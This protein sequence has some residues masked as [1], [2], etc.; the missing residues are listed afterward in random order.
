[1]HV[2]PSRT[3]D[4]CWSS[5]SFPLPEKGWRWTCLRRSPSLESAHE[6]KMPRRTS[7]ASAGLLM[8]ASSNAWTN[9]TLHGDVGWKMALLTK[10]ETALA[11]GIGF[12]LLDWFVKKCPKRGE[13]RKLLGVKVGSDLHFDESEVVAFRSYL[14]APWPLPPKGQRP[15]IPDKIKQDIKLE[16]HLACA[17]CG[18]MDNGE[19]AHIEAVASTFNNSPDNL[20]FLC[21]NH[22]TKFDLGFKPA[23]NVSVE[24][25]QAAKSVKRSSR[26][27]MMR[28]EADTIKG[29]AGLLDLI[30]N[31]SEKIASIEGTPTAKVYEAEV[32]SLLKQSSS[33]LADAV[34]KAAKGG[35]VAS[36]LEVQFKK[37]AP[38]LAKL[39]EKGASATT[40]PRMKALVDDVIEESVDVLAALDEQECPH[41]GG[42]GTT[43]LVGDYCKF[44]RGSQLVSSERASAYEPTDLDEVPCP[45]CGGRGTTG[46][47]GDYCGFCR[48]SQGV[49]KEKAE[50]YDE[51]DVDE[52]PCPRCNGRGTTGLVGNYCAYCRGSAYV[53]RSK[54]AAYEADD[55]DE[56][57][58]PHCGGRGTVGL[59]G[60]ECPFC[61]ASQS[62]SSTKA[63]A[64]D[65]SKLDEFDCPHCNGRGVT[66]LNGTYCA[67][68]NGSQRISER[69]LNKYDQ[70]EID[71]VECPH[72][73]GQG[74]IGMSGE[75]CKLC[76]G[77]Q[78]VSEEKSTSYLSRKNTR[79]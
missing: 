79:R 35:N 20:I 65:E 66:G 48:G 6:G 9:I 14:R 32:K 78:T 18:H 17:I 2:Q 19:V 34:A 43:G 11:L 15:T 61:R 67:Y 10:I 54:H 59:V 29:F 5:G 63:K 12:E 23:S 50:S 26:A 36:V 25:I 55:I 75:F 39:L 44:C 71:E 56:V 41:C 27:R 64:Y 22:H 46:F 70:S 74:F 13:T 62:V 3:T 58:C 24:E 1:M 51:D 47:V 38:A 49:S 42:R 30:R 68:C 76:R 60:D 8:F 45:R 31:L 28:A 33:H 21:P 7:I 72:C 53:S 57:A 37:H 73:R 69:K 52:L 40:P 4:L 16:A 77:N